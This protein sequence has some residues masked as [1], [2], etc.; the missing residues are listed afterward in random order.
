[1][2]SPGQTINSHRGTAPDRFGMCLLCPT[3]WGG[4]VQV[5]G[6]A[7][8][9]T[10]THPERGR[11]AVPLVEAFFSAA[12]HRLRHTRTIKRARSSSGGD[13]RPATK[14]PGNQAG[15]SQETFLKRDGVRNDDFPGQLI[16]P[17]SMTAVW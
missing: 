16:P 15:E 2:R 7:V 10:T 6:A 9:G 8:A 14:P 11:F 12:M 3:H 5:A 1:M 17:A 13:A 4:V